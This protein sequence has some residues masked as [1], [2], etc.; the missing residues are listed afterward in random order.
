MNEMI[1]KDSPEVFEVIYA[2]LKGGLYKEELAFLKKQFGENDFLEEY[3][4]VTEIREL[5]LGGFKDAYES[6]SDF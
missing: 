1:L 4:L 2:Q 3:I 6:G 5:A